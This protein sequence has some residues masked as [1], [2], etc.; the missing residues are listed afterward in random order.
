MTVVFIPQI[1]GNDDQSLEKSRAVFVTR[2]GTA[3]Q[4]CALLS[5]SVGAYVV[6]A[7]Q[8][9]S[10]DLRIDFQSHEETRH[11]VISSNCPHEL[12]DLPRV[13]Q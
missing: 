9:P 4:L 10:A 8:R 13:A 7:M 3:S 1:I 6:S 2:I 12:D 5:A 11:H